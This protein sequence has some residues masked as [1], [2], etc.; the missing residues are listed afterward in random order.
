[1]DTVLGLFPQFKEVEDEDGFAG[2]L[3]LNTATV[4]SEVTGYGNSS[5][6]YTVSRS[7]PNLADADT[8]HIPKTIDDGGRTLQFQ[9]V[10][11]RSDNTMNVDNYEIT[12]RYTAIVTFSGTR[13][14]S[15]YYA[16]QIKETDLSRLGRTDDNSAAAVSTAISFP[17][18][19]FICPSLAPS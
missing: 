19:S 16:G 11:W 10:Q 7:Y 13:T 18:I 6:P 9:D 3:L 5:T 14:Y 15:V 8:Q 2:T 12:E 4:K 17:C 1:M